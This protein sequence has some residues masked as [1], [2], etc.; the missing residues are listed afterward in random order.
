MPPTVSE[1]AEKE[2]FEATAP[3]DV[4]EAVEEIKYADIPKVPT[5]DEFPEW[6]KKLVPGELFPLKG[7]LFKFVGMTPD[8]AVVLQYQGPT[9]KSQ[10]E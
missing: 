1:E 10:K 4:A 2:M 6:A 5:F 9:G 3:T 7:S 8:F